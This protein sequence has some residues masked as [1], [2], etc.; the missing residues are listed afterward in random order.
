MKVIKNGSLVVRNYGAWLK[1]SDKYCLL[2]MNSCAEMMIQRLDYKSLT[3]DPNCDVF[4]MKE[5]IKTL[6][7]NDWVYVL[8]GLC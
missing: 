7:Y 5:I 4:I 2:K 1:L 6:I 8:E 3:D